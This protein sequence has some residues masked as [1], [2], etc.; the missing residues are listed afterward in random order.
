ML[1]ECCDWLIGCRCR[2]S[3]DVINYRYFH[4]VQSAATYCVMWR[5]GQYSCGM[6][7]YQYQTLTPMTH[8][9]N[10]RL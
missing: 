8:N 6:L 2:C 5:L 1:T 3:S 10:I 9:I 4:D 7:I